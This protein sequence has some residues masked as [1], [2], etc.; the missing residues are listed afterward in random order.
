MSSISA[1]L[2][3]AGDSVTD[4]PVVQW[5]AWANGSR[6]CAPDD[7]LRD[8]RGP[9]RAPATAT[10]ARREVLRT[11]TSVSMDKAENSASGPMARD[12]GAAK[13][14]QAA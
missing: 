4:F 2:L 11:K 7:E 12:G 3:P 5:P 8:I 10:G 13:S 6:E 14:T 1:A 9:R